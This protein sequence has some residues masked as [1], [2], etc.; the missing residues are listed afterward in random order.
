MGDSEPFEK[1]K[2]VKFIHSKVIGKGFSVLID[3]LVF[4]SLNM[5]S[6]NNLI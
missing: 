2:E 1:E 4:Y 6:F 5:P 3:L